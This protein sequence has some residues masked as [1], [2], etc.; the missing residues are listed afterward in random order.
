MSDWFRKQPKIGT[1]MP[2][3][4]SLPS[5]PWTKATTP[6]Q[7][8][9]NM[10]TTSAKVVM[11]HFARS[12]VRTLN[13]QESQL[14]AQVVTKLRSMSEFSTMPDAQ[15]AEVI[16]NIAHALQSAPLTINFKTIGWFDNPNHHRVYKQMYE[17]GDHVAP[18]PDG[19]AERRI[20]GS[21]ANKAGK[22]D[23]VDTTVSFGPNIASAARQGIARF[24]GTG[25][26]E[27]RD[28]VGS[29]VVP[30]AQFNSKARQVFGALNFGRR[31]F[32]AN[33][34]Y[35]HHQFVLKERLKINAIYYMGDTFTPGIDHN[36]RVTYGF[37]PALILHASRDALNDIIN[38][39]YRSMVLRNSQ[40]PDVMVE[41]HIYERVV[42]SQTV[43]KLVMN[44]FA[45]LSDIRQLMFN[46]GRTDLTVEQ[47][48]NNVKIFANVN[49]IKLEWFG[50]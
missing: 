21:E 35:G 3:L 14:H 6:T 9:A 49:K 34:G 4:P 11:H 27:R 45:F 29:V 22:R 32:G 40:M 17:R 39:C 23:E 18:G 10:Q 24:M 46:G 36:S 13:K 50:V 20:A 42:F 2:A 30:N 19:T 15:I 1:R 26:G 7:L 31:T 25:G 12:E 33:F 28:D 38:S 44:R 37:L 41:A 5:S 47:A 48:E 16:K 8:P 43:E